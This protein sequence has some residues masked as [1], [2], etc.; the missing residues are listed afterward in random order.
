ME[1]EEHEVT[2]GEM[3]GGD[4]EIG[5]DS[6]DGGTVN[7]AVKKKKREKIEQQPVIKNQIRDKA[8]KNKEE[9]TKDER[10][11]TNIS[12]IKNKIRRNQEWLKLKR[13]KKKDKR[14]RQEERKKEAEACEERGEEAPAKL[15]PKTID[16][17][18]EYDE[19]TV[20]GKEGTEED[21]EVEHD[22]AT[23]E[24]SAYFAK[25]YEPKVLITCSD[26]PHSRTIAFMKELTRIIP[27]SE[28]K[29]RKK[30]VCEENREGFDK[31]RVHGHT[32]DQRG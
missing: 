25:T 6:D 11:I 20:G 17:M 7:K 14:M 5:G 23:D 27:N 29:W 32:G 28:P 18:R 3:E 30:L 8:A 2:G 10:R 13:E 21:E 26:N 31:E 24:F 15:V 22:V 16:S 12:E 9:K 1:F 4:M 19:T